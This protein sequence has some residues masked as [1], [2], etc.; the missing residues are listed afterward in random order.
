MQPM[1]VQDRLSRREAVE[2]HTALEKLRAR[3]AHFVLVG[4]DKRPL[5]KAWQKTRPDF[6]NVEGHAE[7]GG[8]VG[9]IPAS[10][11]CFVVDIDEGGENGV[12]AVRGV[13]GEPVGVIATQRPGGFHAWYRAPADK[14]GNRKWKLDGAAGDI[15]GS[16][17]Y[18]IL[19]DPAKLANGLA[20]HFD[21]AQPAD[22]GKLPRPTTH[23]ARG[24]AAVSSAPVGERNTTLNR[25]TFRAAKDGTLDR[26]VFRDAALDAGLS[27]GE[28]ETTLASAA[29]GAATAKPQLPRNATGLALALTG[30]G[31]AWRFNVRAMRHEFRENADWRE[32]NDR[33]EARIQEAIANRYVTGEKHAPL[34]FGRETWQR[35]LNALLANAETDPFREG[36]VA[37]PPWDGMSRLDGWLNEVFDTDPNCPL[38]AWAARFIFLGPVWRAFKPGTKLDEM[39]VLIGPQGCGK[40]TALRWALPPEHPEW[41]ADGLH[42]AADAKTRAEALQSRVIVEAAEMA[43]STRA[44][45]ESLKAFLSRTDDGA[46]RLAYRRDP[47]TALRRCIVVGTSNDPTCL[48][49]DPSGNRRFVSVVLRGGDPA[50]LRAYLNE[51]REQLWAEALAGYRNGV[52]ARLPDDLH[53]AQSATNEQVRRRDDILEDTLADWLRTAP[54]RFTL[55]EAAVGCRIVEPSREARLSMRDQR[56]LGAALITASFVKRREC[57]DGQRVMVWARR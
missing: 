33:T 56:R 12:E 25:E 41:F 46:V 51:H 22:P 11:K 40:S 34:R 30:L 55:A 20:R 10:L 52:E 45:L 17:G 47:E 57:V 43:G 7:G 5:S 42:L 26:D 23:G 49:N 24:P 35:S 21:D 3:G 27:A 13:L 44:E 31:I 39:P 36:V 2:T 37:Q 4:P 53:E 8:L 6:S 54:E 15:R 14:I 9:V 28:V 1:T 48:P 50:A 18:A 16:A 32:A 38:T 29:A 19:W